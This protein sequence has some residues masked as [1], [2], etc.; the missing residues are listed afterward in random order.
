MG[1]ILPSFVWDKKEYLI[2]NNKSFENLKEEFEKEWNAKK[3]NIIEEVKGKKDRD[4][5]IKL[6]VSIGVGIATTIIGG[7]IGGLAYF[8]ATG[9][10]FTAGAAGTIAIGE[11][12]TGAAIAAGAASAAGAAGATGTVL[13]A[14]SIENARA[15]NPDKFGFLYLLKILSENYSGAFL[16]NNRTNQNNQQDN[17]EIDYI[18]ILEINEF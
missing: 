10:I 8:G 7:G 4:Y 13:I 6:G 5:Y 3:D 11:V 9:A 16:I 15:A 18:Q 2:G 1:F 12:A 17:N 14:N